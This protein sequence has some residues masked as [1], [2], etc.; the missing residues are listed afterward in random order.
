MLVS[1][2]PDL[3]DQLLGKNV[4]DDVEVK[5]TF[6]DEYH[7]EDLAGKDAVFKV[8]INSLKVKELP[9]ADDDFAMDVSEFDTLDEYKADI[10]AK[11]EKANE[12]KA[13][14]E[15]QQNVIDAVCANTQIDIPDEMIDSQIDSM[16]RDM[17]MQMRYQGIDLNT[18]MQYTGQTMGYNP[19]AV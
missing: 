12:D 9:E 16:I 8:K 10:K 3:R 19:R 7:A 18:Y 4:G 2:F 11:L 17:D 14:H 15:T 1:S 13:K 6:P 5:V